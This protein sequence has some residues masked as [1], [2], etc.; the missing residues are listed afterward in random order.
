MK[1][2]LPFL[3]AA[4]VQAHPVHAA[5]PLTLDEA[6]SLAQ[7]KHPQIAEAKENLAGAEARAGQASSAYYP[8][9]SVVSD[10]S[11]GR[12]F[13]T[14]L[15]K[16][17]STEVDS[18]TVQLKQTIY[19][20]G[21]TAGVVAAAR[22]YR[23][24]AEQ[25]V[26]LTRIDLATRVKVA[27][28]QLLAAQ[29]QVTATR[30][31][32]AAREA[33]QLQAVEFFKLGLRAKVDVARA[34]ANLF[35]EKTTLI[36]AENRLALAR[37]ELANALGLASLDDFS[38]VEPAPATVTLPARDEA[39]GEA[40]RSRA[41]MRQLADL[42]GAAGSA[43]KA[44]KSSYL[45]TISGSASLGY[46]DRDFPPNG[47]VWGVGLSL[48][49][50]IFSGFSSVEQVREATAAQS[51]IAAR[52]ESLK[53]QIVKEVDTAWFG[54]QEAAARM[55]STEKQS[56]AAEENRALAEGR[57]Q[58]GVGGIIEV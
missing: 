40:L 10:W 8:Q 31:A 32:V 29:M 25:G 18:T 23:D 2:Y 6:L 57:Y 16:V 26:A 21:R 43:L 5:T 17:R 12:S 1:R 15:E 58:E 19:D 14:A 44:A 7:K 52:Q 9:I 45:P 11:K 39:C 46:A 35:E 20:F 13:L 54:V 38:P 42:S 47:Q 49:V 27:F 28:Y 56:A 51:A 55:V 41:E 4:L 48:T 34:E 22:G 36:R 50:P 30:D 37:V 24:A 53:L 3:I 33:V